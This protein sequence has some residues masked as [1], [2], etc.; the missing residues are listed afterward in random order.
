MPLTDMSGDMAE[1]SVTDFFHLVKTWSTVVGFWY[2]PGGNWRVW[3][4]VNF[5]LSL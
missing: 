5:V 2:I 1:T 3:H 4:Y